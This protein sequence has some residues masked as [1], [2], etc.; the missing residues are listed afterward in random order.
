[1]AE[2]PRRAGATPRGELGRRGE[3][4]AARKLKSKG[5][6]IVATNVRTRR[7]EIDI[8]AEKGK[9]LV[10]VEVRAKASTAFGTPEQSISPAKQSHMVAS[11][12]EYLQ[13]NGAESREWRIDLVA[14][15]FGADGKPKRLDIVEHAV[16][17]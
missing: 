3:E 9:L 15:E 8:V 12:Y 13:A 10:F 5:Y 16:Q 14:V 7:G 4:F 2:D 1:M 17:L 6:T 11:A